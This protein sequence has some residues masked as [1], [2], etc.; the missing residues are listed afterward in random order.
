MR[1][2][3]QL[4]VVSKILRNVPLIHMTEGDQLFTCC[5]KFLG[6]EPLM[7]AKRTD[8]SSIHGVPSPPPAHLTT[9][10]FR[11]KNTLMSY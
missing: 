4:L 1:R 6:I 5:L 8:N 11:R 9:S 10:H 2:N 3:F 7:A